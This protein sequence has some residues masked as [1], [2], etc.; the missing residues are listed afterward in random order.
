[1]VTPYRPLK[2]SPLK[3]ASTE[4][5]PRN[6]PEGNAAWQT[7]APVGIFPH[8]NTQ[9][10]IPGRLLSNGQI[11][12]QSI[13][14]PQ[15]QGQIRT[16]GSYELLNGVKGNLFQ[17]DWLKLNLTLSEHPFI[18]ALKTTERQRAVQGSEIPRIRQML[19][20]QGYNGGGVKIGILD[21]VQQDPKTKAWTNHAHS[22]LVSDIINDPVWGV[23]PGAQVEDLGKSFVPRKDIAGDH[24]Q[25]FTQEVLARY[26]QIMQYQIQQIQRVLAKPDPSLRI[27][28]MTWGATL[29]RFYLGFIEELM[30]KKDENGFLKYPNLR[31]QILG[32]ALFGTINEQKQRVIDAVNQVFLQS[33]FIQNV[34]AQYIEATRQAARRGL[35]LVAA[36]SNEGVNDTPGIVYPPSAQM[37]FFGQSP[38]VIA[39]AAADTRQNPGNRAQYEVSAFSSRGD[40]QRYNPTIA[41]PGQEIGVSLYRGEHAH[42][43]VT[44]GTSFATPFTCGVIAM[45]LQ[46]NPALT[47][48]QV[49]AKLQNTA[50]QNPRYGV[51]DYGAGFLNAEAAVLG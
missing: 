15:V 46:K 34:Q 35:I 14:G 11:V 8:Q 48:D 23:A 43:L 49:K 26:T 40:G 22:E 42:N 47:F 6:L 28:S 33:P 19:T 38:Y 51:A 21:A 29:S 5:N 27:L 25:A 2:P 31:R 12:T 17:D 39:V 9:L 32:P 16:D 20:N 50:I 10:E 44:Q 45:M 7:I 18:N 37:G 4:M 3:P 41:A 36:T 24:Y 30:V 13:W 1:M